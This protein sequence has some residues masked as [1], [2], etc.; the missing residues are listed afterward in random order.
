MRLLGE[1]QRRFRVAAPL[2]LDMQAAQAEQLGRRILGQLMEG[3]FGAGAVAR[4]LRRLRAEQVG[5]RLLLQMF[6]G[7]GGGAAGELCIAGADCDHA[8]REGG[9]ALFLAPP[10]GP[11]RQMH[12]QVP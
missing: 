5:Q 7:L 9:I 8:A 6:A 11:L 3:G 4:E 2:R 1:M 12:G 10:L